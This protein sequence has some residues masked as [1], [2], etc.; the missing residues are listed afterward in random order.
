MIRFTVVGKGCA[1]EIDLVE[2]GVNR[3]ECAPVRLK[4][5]LFQQI[6]PELSQLRDLCP[7]RSPYL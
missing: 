4:P 6:P 5:P 3:V 1:Y 2:R 7:Q